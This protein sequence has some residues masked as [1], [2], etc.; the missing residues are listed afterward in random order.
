MPQD[1]AL[2]KAAYKG[3]IDACQELLDQGVDVNIEGAGNRTP[4]HRA[5]GEDNDECA[6]FLIERGANVNYV[7]GSG[8]TPMHWAAI[9]GAL[10]CGKLLEKHGAGF[11]DKTKTGMSPLHMAADNGRTEFVFWL[12]EHKGVVDTQSERDAEGKTAADLAREKKHN[13]I[14]DRLDPKKSSCCTVM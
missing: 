6:A 9:S 2:H 7:D 5:V 4:L 14:G 12:L 8:R 11:T 3:E 13:D 1:T 10:A